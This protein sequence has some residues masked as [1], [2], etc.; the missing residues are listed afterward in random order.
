MRKLKWFTLVEI[1][2]VIVIIGILIW[3]LVPRMQSAQWRARD[4]AR[5]NDLSQIQS[6]IVTS[7]T[8]KWEWPNSGSWATWWMSVDKISSKLIAAWLNWVPHDPIKTNTVRLWSAAGTNMSGWEYAYMVWRKNW[9]DWAWF[10]LMA[11]TE[12][13]WWSNWVYC[14][15]GKN[16]DAAGNAAS[17]TSVKGW[18][19]TSTDDLKDV[20][21]CTKL[22][23][24]T[25]KKCEVNTWS[26]CYY[27]DTT[28]LRYI[29]VY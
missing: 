28:E 15:G 6:A 24:S 26:T 7:Y 18:L 12:V 23:L 13:E 22:E 1:L 4:V 29:L 16:T 27:T 10:V 19:I 9:I 8:D 3:A 20:V 17:N 14:S 5:K 2:I 11:H 25:D 21:A